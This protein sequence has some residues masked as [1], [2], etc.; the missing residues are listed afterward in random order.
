M[1]A[2]ANCEIEFTDYEEQNLKTKKIGIIERLKEKGLLHYGSVIDDDAVSFITQCEKPSGYSED[3]EFSKLQ[4]REIIKDE[5]FY[6]TSRG[7]Q[8]NIYILEPHEMPAYNERKNRNNLKNIK[9]R[10]RA[11]YL[12]DQSILGEEHLK[13][14]EFEIFRNASLE[15]EMGNSLKKRC[16]Y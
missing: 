5:G 4:L 13:K 6:V 8:G 2:L 1:Q 14:L 16:R 10:T 12:I 3:W 9:Q 7:R 11:L 15:I